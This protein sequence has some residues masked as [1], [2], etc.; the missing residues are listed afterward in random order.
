[1][2]RFFITLIFASVIVFSVNCERD[3]ENPLSSKDTQDNST[4]LI[5]LH[6][7]NTWVVKRTSYDS[8]GTAQDSDT[9]LCKVDYDTTFL[10][11]KWYKTSWGFLNNKVDGV[12]QYYGS[13][14][15][16]QGIEYSTLTWKY[17][18][19]IGHQYKPFGANAR[20]TVIS[21]DEEYTTPTKTF[22]CYHYQL[23]Y[24]NTNGY[25]QDYFICP[26]IG[27]VKWEDGITLPSGRSY[28]TIKYEL[29]T[30]TIK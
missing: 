8:L 18:S 29:L 24:D 3:K 14:S 28:T 11:E 9:I 2:T 13:S 5:P 1:M 21:V 23:T 12:W 4:V 10:N 30:Y 27:F 15:N 20:I 19:E 17:P 7:E 25:Q 16:V 26:G 22:I 6:L